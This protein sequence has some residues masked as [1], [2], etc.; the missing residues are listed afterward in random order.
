ME[1]PTIS[2]AELVYYIEAMSVDKFEEGLRH[3]HSWVGRE[4]LQ[5]DFWERV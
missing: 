4:S 2:M 1:P 5:R 3:F